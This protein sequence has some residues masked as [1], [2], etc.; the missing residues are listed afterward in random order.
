MDTP[1][2]PSSGYAEKIAFDVSR[3]I[4]FPGFNVPLESRYRDVGF[5][6]NIDKIV[7]FFFD[8]L[9][10]VFLF[11]GLARFKFSANARLSFEKGYERKT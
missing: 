3:L 8:L 1:N 11:K 7:F 6:S 4:D 9:K 10:R 5:F 2:S